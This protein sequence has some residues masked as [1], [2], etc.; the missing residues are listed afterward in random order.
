MDGDGADGVGK[1]GVL[2]IVLTWNPVKNLRGLVRS[3]VPWRFYD[4][5]SLYLMHPGPLVHTDE[6]MCG[7]GGGE[8]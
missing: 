5:C 6:V 1:L 8:G 4:A 3:G 7:G 2:W